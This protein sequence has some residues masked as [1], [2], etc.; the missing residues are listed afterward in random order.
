[1][2]SALTQTNLVNIWK[3]ML[4]SRLLDAQFVGIRATHYGKIKLLKNWFKLV[5][6]ESI[7][8]INTNNFLNLLVECVPIF[9]CILI[10]NR[11]ISTKKTTYRVLWTRITLSPYH[12]YHYH[13]HPLPYPIKYHHQKTL[14]PLQPRKL[15]IA[16]NAVTRH[17]SREIWYV[18]ISYN[19]FQTQD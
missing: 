19:I 9:E 6:S 15:I 4:E 16:T 8:L 3:L 10:K 2:W 18:T 13:Y 7:E 11:T 17:L 1:M 5:N 14:N 12:H